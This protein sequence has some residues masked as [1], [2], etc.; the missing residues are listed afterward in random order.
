[1]H[2]ERKR[3]DD[4]DGDRSVHQHNSNR[5]VVGKGRTG[6]ERE[7]RPQEGGQED[8]IQEEIEGGGEVSG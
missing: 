4:C 2:D 8:V 3:H 5:P 7:E 6:Q 1:M